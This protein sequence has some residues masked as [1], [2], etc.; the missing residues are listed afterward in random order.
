MMSEPSM[1]VN[2]VSEL[3]V[4]RGPLG[5]F[6]VAGTGGKPSWCSF[7]DVVCSFYDWPGM[8]SWAL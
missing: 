7:L 3:S 6:G 4:L 8:E 5:S 1:D 2:L